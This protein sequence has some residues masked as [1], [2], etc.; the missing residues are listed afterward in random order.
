MHVWLP[1]GPMKLLDEVGLDV[2]AHVTKVMSPLF[3]ER[4]ITLQKVDE[5]LIEGGLKG[6]KSGKGFY[7]Y[8]GKSKTSPI[9]EGIYEH[10]GGKNR[11]EIPFSEI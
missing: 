7:L 11:K 3:A 1:V 6:R 8:D 2:G 4:D 5:K 9:N 10:F